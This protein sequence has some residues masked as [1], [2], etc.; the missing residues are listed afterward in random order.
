MSPVV[1]TD[2]SYLEI[3]KDDSCTIA[4]HEDI[5]YEERKRLFQAAADLGYQEVVGECHDPAS[6]FTFL[7]V[8]K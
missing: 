8:I 6:G 1:E 5:R 2:H 7:E 3:N 4:M